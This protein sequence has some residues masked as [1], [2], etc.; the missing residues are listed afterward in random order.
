[1]VVGVLAAGLAWQMAAQPSPLVS[2]ASAATVPQAVARSIGS[3]PDAP[4]TGNPL[5]SVTVSEF[6]DYRC[7]YCRMMQPTLAALLAK[8]KRVRLVAKEWPIFGGPSVTAARIAL[9]AR[10]Q[11]KYAAVHEALFQLPR[12]MDEESIR[13]A[14]ASAGVDMGRLDRD[15][16][17]RGK[18]ID[19]ELATVDREARAVGF[20]G[21]PGFVIGT[22]I[23]PGAIPAAGLD[24]MVNRAAG[25]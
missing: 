10:W 15:L 13:A 25:N 14:A 5:G 2:A 21:T 12:T 16:A 1:L 20:Q 24:D 19:A 7:P 18:E 8:D 17:S 11:G 3:D 22:L 6:F 23:A 4:V 9:A